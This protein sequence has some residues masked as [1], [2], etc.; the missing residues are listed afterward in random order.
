MKPKRRS[1]LPPWKRPSRIAW[2]ILAVAGTCWLILHMP[3]PRLERVRVGYQISSSSARKPLPHVDKRLSPT[4][5]TNSAPDAETRRPT[6]SQPLKKIFAKAKTFG[7]LFGIVGI[8]AFLGGL[9]EA[10]RWYMI[11][12]KTMSK[13]I[14]LS[15]LPQ[16][17]GL[18]MPTALCSNA[19]ANS[20]LVS[21]HTDG[22]IKTSALIVGGMANSYLAYVSHSIRIMYPVIGAIG[23][24]G[25]LYFTTQFSGGLLVLFG[26]LLWHRWYSEAHDSSQ[27]EHDIS[28]EQTAPLPWAKALTMATERSCALLFRMVCITLPLMAGSEWLLK[29]GAFNFWEQTVPA[30]VNQFFP[31]ELVTIVVAQMGGLVQSSAVAANLRADGL[32]SNIQILL[33]MLVGSAVGNPFRTLRRNLPSALGIFPVPLALIIVITMQFSRLVVTILAIGGVVA[34]MRS[35]LQ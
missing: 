10:R 25:A 23:I 14:S 20:I 11:L 21:S 13:L 6:Q 31:A 8:A 7:R 1:S 3:E 19:A 28:Q 24:P 22:K 9:I 4:D 2:F 12:S 34:Y 18:S 32:I 15:K 27:A 35:T 17:V 26:A 29:S 30:Q 16:I 33:A 5:A